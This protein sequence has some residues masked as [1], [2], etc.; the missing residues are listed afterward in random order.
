MVTVTPGQ[1]GATGILDGAAD[2][3]VDRLR[4]TGRGATANAQRMRK[5]NLPVRETTRARA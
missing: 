4:M 5:R 3:A 2:A 1:D